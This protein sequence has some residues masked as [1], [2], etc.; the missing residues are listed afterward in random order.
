M[1]LVVKLIK[2]GNEVREFDTVEHGKKRKKTGK[3]IMA[4]EGIKDDATLNF[5]FFFHWKEKY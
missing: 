5:F 4:T 2:K 3:K 1:K